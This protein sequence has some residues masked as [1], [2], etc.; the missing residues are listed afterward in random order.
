MLLAGIQINVMLA[1]FNL[2]PIPPMDGSKVAISVLP[3]TYAGW[4]LRLERYGILPLL[5]LF[6]I[7]ATNRMIMAIVDPIVNAALGLL[8]HGAM[9]GFL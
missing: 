3:M 8:I 4:F 9:G 6:M 5:I 7:P 1:I 2:L